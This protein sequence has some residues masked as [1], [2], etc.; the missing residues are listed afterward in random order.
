MYL[1]VFW[2]SCNKHWDC[3]CAVNGVLGGEISTP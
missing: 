2:L 3:T 1:L